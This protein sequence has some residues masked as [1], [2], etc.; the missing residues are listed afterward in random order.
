MSNL[1]ENVNLAASYAAVLALD[2]DEGGE[3]AGAVL[4][5]MEE[6]QYSAAYLVETLTATGLDGNGDWKM[7]D[8]ILKTIQDASKG[9]T[10]GTDAEYHR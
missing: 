9:V 10:E 6:E 7:N 1:P 3:G 5:D 4:Q 8:S 2:A